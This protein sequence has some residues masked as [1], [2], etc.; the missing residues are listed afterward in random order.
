MILADDTGE[1]EKA[2][3]LG[4]YGLERPQGTLGLFLSGF[5]PWWHDHDHEQDLSPDTAGDPRRCI[6]RSQARIGECG[7]DTACASRSA[8][9]PGV[10]LP[11]LAR[12]GLARRVRPG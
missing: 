1:A 4:L 9:L 8:D 7:D 2:Q 3:V 11:D 5:H 6:P 10:D 12:C